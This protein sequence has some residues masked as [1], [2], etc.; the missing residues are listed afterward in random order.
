MHEDPV[1]RL[2]ADLGRKSLTCDEPLDGID[3]HG[4]Q[5]PEILNSLF[6]VDIQPSP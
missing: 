1:V 4:A 2:D 6:H 3:V 5:R